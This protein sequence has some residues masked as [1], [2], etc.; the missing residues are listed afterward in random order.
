MGAIFWPKKLRSDESLLVRLA[1]AIHWISLLGAACIM[2]MAIGNGVDFEYHH[3][4]LMTIIA[5]TTCSV[6][7]AALGRCVRYVLA[8]E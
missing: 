4:Y 7:L 2:L 1:R 3:V 5:G 6:L 8:N